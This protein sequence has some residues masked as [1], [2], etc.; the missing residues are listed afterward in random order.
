MRF[1]DNLQPRQTYSSISLDRLAAARLKCNRY[2]RL[3]SLIESTRL[4]FI[5]GFR[6]V[7]TK[8]QGGRQDQQSH[9]EAMPDSVEPR[10]ETDKRAQAIAGRDSLWSLCPGVASEDHGLR[11]ATPTR[12]GT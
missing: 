3:W 7:R 5:D 9:L 11:Q 12:P 2:I 10:E 4:L 8:H 6:V 1:G